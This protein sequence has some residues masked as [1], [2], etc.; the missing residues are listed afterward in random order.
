MTDRTKTT[1]CR[2][3]PAEHKALRLHCLKTDTTPNDLLRGLLE[4]FIL[5]GLEDQVTLLQGGRAK[6]APVAAPTATVTVDC[7]VL[8]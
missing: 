1:A 6:G 3:T 7:E 2:L 4:P 5:D 8:P